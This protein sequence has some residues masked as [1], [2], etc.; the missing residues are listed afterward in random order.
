MVRNRAHVTILFNRGT[1]QEAQAAPPAHA[2]AKGH[3]YVNKQKARAK[4]NGY[5][6]SVVAWLRA[7]PP[8]HAVG[9]YLAS[10]E[11]PPGGSAAERTEPGDMKMFARTLAR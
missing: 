5:R 4:E 6:A 10:F 2:M 11:P 7:L 1:A 3:S 9:A 8:E